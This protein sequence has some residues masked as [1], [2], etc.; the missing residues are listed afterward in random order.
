MHRSIRALAIVLG[1]MFAMSAITMAAVTFDPE[2]GEGF[3]GKGDV[4]Y[5]FGWNNKQL[6]DNAENVEFRVS[7]GSVVETTWTCKRDDGTQTQERERTTTTTYEG[8]VESVTR[9]RNQI[10]GFILEGYDGDP[11]TSTRSDGPAIG[12]CATGW[13]VIEGPTTGDPEPIGGGFE[14]SKDNGIT[15]TELLE[16]P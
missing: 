11:T 3:V 12:S 5:T 14:V 13:S 10:T 4:Q 6:Q 2:T 1:A 7:S 8:L 16:K 9:E 15:W